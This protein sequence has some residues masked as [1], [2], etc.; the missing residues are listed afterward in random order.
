MAWLEVI[1]RLRRWLGVRGREGTRALVTLL[2]AALVLGVAA[3]QPHDPAAARL[4]A[5]LQYQASR[6]QVAEWALPAG[7]YA[8]TIEMRCET[9]ALCAQAF[10]API[11]APWQESYSFVGHLS[12]DGK[13]MSY[14]GANIYRGRPGA[15][16]E[17]ACDDPHATPFSGLCI[18]GE[19]ADAFLRISAL[20]GP[21]YGQLTIWVKN[22]LLYSPRSDGD[23]HV[24]PCPCGPEGI[25]TPTPGVPMTLSTRDFL[26]GAEPPAG[27]TMAVQLV[28]LP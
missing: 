11:L 1:H 14:Y 9:E 2:V 18:F 23:N 6:L 17:G 26:S 22:S 5:Q 16:P 3:A 7:E 21:L 12:S 24:L 15:G 4:A 28:K 20:P 27:V 13:R 19:R 8:W 10:G 25:E